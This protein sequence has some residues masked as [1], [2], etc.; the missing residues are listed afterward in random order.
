VFS[1]PKGG[2]ALLCHPPRHLDGA[3]EWAKSVGGLAKGPRRITFC[4][5]I[6][7]RSRC[8]PRLSSNDFRTYYG[9][10]AVN[11]AAGGGSPPRWCVAHSTGRATAQSLSPTAPACPRSGPSLAPTDPGCTAY[12]AVVSATGQ[13]AR[14][15]VTALALGRAAVD[16]D[17]ATAGR[18]AAQRPMGGHRTADR[19]PPAAR[20][21]GPRHCSG[22]TRPGARFTAASAGVRCCLGRSIA[23]TPTWHCRC[24]HEIMS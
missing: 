16:R 7:L 22:G 3:E 2:Q 4:A 15:S 6:P 9:G 21:R 17:G 19:L 10:R 13:P 5:L 23:A 11:A 12:H 14:R 24:G 18:R 1:L 8:F 20:A